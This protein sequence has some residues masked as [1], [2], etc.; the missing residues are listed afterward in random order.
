LGIIENLHQ[1]TLHRKQVGLLPEGI[2]RMAPPAH[3]TK[4]LARVREE[5]R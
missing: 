4:R 1:Y 5:L 2:A 3:A